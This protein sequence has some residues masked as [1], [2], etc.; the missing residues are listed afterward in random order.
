MAKRIGLLR[1]SQE[2]S[3]ISSGLLPFG[4]D[5]L[6]RWI[7]VNVERRNRLNLGFSLTA[8]IQLAGVVITYLLQK[9]KNDLQEGAKM[10]MK[11]KQNAIKTKNHG[12]HFI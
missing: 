7:R 11:D 2:T 9:T 6:K 4:F 8:V 5:T 3:C 1:I 12:K 10:K